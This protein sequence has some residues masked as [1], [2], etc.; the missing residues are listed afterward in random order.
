M[1]SCKLVHLSCERMYS[2]KTK[3]ALASVLYQYTRHPADQ[4]IPMSRVTGWI[5]SEYG[6]SVNM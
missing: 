3:M 6:T 1:N 2:S 4:G 5:N